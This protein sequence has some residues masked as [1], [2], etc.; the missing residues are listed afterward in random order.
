M[1]HEP[2]LATT[3]LALTEQLMHINL[4]VHR[5]HHGVTQVPTYSAVI[6]IEVISA[7]LLPQIMV[8]TIT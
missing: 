1:V 2:A 4:L 3:G 7:S 5:M 8:H 6:V